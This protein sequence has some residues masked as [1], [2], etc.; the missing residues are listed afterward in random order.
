MKQTRTLKEQ[1]QDHIVPLTPQ[2][3]RLIKTIRLFNG[4]SIFL[5]PQVRNR[6]KTMSKDSVA[7]SLRDNGFKDKQ[8]AHGLRSLCRTY[9]SKLGYEKV[10]GELALAHLSTGKDK[11]QAIYDRYDYLK[12]RKEAF[13][14]WGDYC[15]QCGIL[16]DYDQM[17]KRS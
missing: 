8:D 14:K 4:S 11:V 2:L 15:E 13:Q 7:N 1:P 9:L 6:N 5:F 12:E 17:M 3:I 16:L 10:V